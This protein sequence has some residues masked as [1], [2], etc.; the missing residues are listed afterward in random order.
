MQ[1]LRI[2]D[3]NIAIEIVH[4]VVGT[5]QL[6]DRY[7][8]THDGVQL[9]WIFDPESGHFTAPPPPRWISRLAFLN[10]LGDAYIAIELAAEPPTRN[11]DE[12]DAAFLQRR[13]VAATLRTLLA[14]VNSSKYIDL[15]RADLRAGLLQIEAL[16]LL[17][18]GGAL[19]ILNAEILP[20]EAYT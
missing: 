9:G 8:A 6:S 14:K 12:T 18:A 7:V 10:R 2:D 3:N 17:P 15:G 16:H 11:T 20:E 1:L 4:P 5:L 13:Q 19:N